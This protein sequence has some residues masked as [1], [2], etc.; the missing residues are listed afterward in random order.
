MEAEPSTL[1]DHDLPSLIGL[2]RVFEAEGRTAEEIEAFRR[3]VD[4]Q[5]Q[6]AAAR[7][8]LAK[9]LVATEDL[10]DAREQL[11]ILKGLI[12]GNP[13]VYELS[14]DAGKE[15]RQA[16]REDYEMALRLTVD[17][18]QRGRLSKKIKAR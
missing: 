11:D 4:L 17:K 14:G 10:R 8:L 12:P 9:R 15:D 7:L 3:I 13:L 5:P 1:G 18:R 6:Y 2:A 16:A